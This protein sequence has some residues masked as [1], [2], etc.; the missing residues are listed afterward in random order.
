MKVVDLMEE[1][2]WARDKEK[3]LYARLPRL[4]ESAK[5]YAEVELFL[6][7]TEKEA[8]HAGLPDKLYELAINQM[9]IAFAA[10]YRQLAATRFPEF[11]PTYE[12]LVE[13]MVER[14]APAK[15]KGHLPKEIKTLEPG[16]MK[17]WTVREQLNRM[18]HVP[19]PHSSDD[20][21]AGCGENLFAL[22]A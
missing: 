11:P 15:P 2:H 9:S 13:A 19:D 14:V 6:T 12:R 16:K 4:E 21:R 5:T 10:S 8:E 7:A 3:R 18:Y 22:L 1:R 20:H 17:A